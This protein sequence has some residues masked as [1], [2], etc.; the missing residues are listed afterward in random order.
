M[1]GSGALRFLRR[2]RLGFRRIV[3]R[4]ALSQLFLLAAVVVVA[5]AMVLVG[6]WISTYLTTS[7]GR[8]VA[9]TAA[10]TIDSLV[11]DQLRFL[12]AGQPLSEDDRTRLNE[13]FR[14]SS[15]A[16]ATPLLQIRIRTLDRQT[17]FESFGGII[18]DESMGDFQTA[19][20]GVVV[21]RVRDMPLEA[22]GPIGTHTL[23]TLEIHTALHR[24]ESREIFGVAD[25][26]YSAKSILDLQ[27]R[28]QLDVWA[29]VGL[30]GLVVIGALYV[31]VARASQTIIAQRATLARN[32]QA[33]RH[34]SEEISALHAASEEL[35]IEASLSNE[36]LLAQVGSDLHDGPIQM[37][38]LIIMRLSK[39][40]REATNPA[41][42]ESLLRSVQLATDTMEELR[43][44]SSGLILPEL[45]DLDLRQTLELAIS[46]HEDAAGTQVKRSLSKL[47]GSATMDVK[48]C[49]YRIVQESLNN[50]FWHGDR[51]KPSVSARLAGNTCHITILNAARPRDLEAG[52]E[53]AGRHLGLRSMRFRVEALGG[54]LQ[55]DLRPGDLTEIVAEIPLGPAP[56]AQSSSSSSP[57]A[58]S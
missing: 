33:S 36:R 15:E 3:R 37:L 12:S 46:R 18:D 42:R 48:T 32:L 39:A 5:G 2:L 4:L 41:A 22:V 11:S 52:A 55:V 20:G 10:A 23:P 35:R 43:N 7:I 26:Y 58:V 24:P 44:I 28:A 40:A 14:I 51:S 45:A 31:M 30:A 27:R 1:R 47:K 49:A 13:V 38:T 9:E 53:Q 17:I 29:V 54:Q 8:G 34:M 57:A 19:A 25:L 16:D 21:S 50:A 56:L 6:S